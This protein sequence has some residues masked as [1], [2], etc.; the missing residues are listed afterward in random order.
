MRILILVLALGWFTLSAE[1]EAG[2]SSVLRQQ[3]LEAERALRS[4]KRSKY[5]RLLGELEEYP[6]YPYLIYQDLRARLASAPASEVRSFLD[7]W[8]D[9]PLAPRVRSAWLETL[10]RHERWHDYLEHYVESNSVA[11]RCDYL[12]AL[13]R[14]GRAEE[15]FPQVDDLWLHARS[16]PDECDPVFNAWRAGGYLAEELAWARV[17]LAIDAGEIGLASYLRRFVVSSEQADVDRWI[18]TRK[19]P[20]RV[21]ELERYPAQNPLAQQALVAGFQYLARRDAEKA[22]EIWTRVSPRRTWRDEDRNAIERQIGLS[23]AY[24][25]KPQAM[26]W[27]ARVLHEDDRPVQEWRVL[28]ALRHGEWKR[29]LRWLAGMNEEDQHSSRW[30]YWTARCHESLGE[31]SEATLIFERLSRERS[32]YGFLAADRIDRPYEFNHQSL[33]FSDEEPKSI[34]D[35]SGIVRA[36]ELLALK[37]WPDARREWF[38]V[39]KE[40]SDLEAAKAAQLAHDWGWHARA[41]ITLAGT[42]HLDD[43]GLRFPTPHQVDVT[44]RASDYALDRAWVFAVARQES[45]FMPDAR[46]PK[47][48]L[49]LMQIMP[50]TGKDI[51]S[52]LK[53]PGFKT[54]DLLDSAT[55]LR[56]GSWYLRDLLNRMRDHRVLAIA[57]Y[58]AG[59]HRTRRWLPADGA[60]DA[61]IWIET[62]PFRETRRY[63]RRVLAYTVIYEMMLDDPSTRISVRLAPVPSKL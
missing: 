17:R 34:A 27:F 38:H 45:A 16:Q 1:A 36:K 47:G 54:R 23:L 3:F 32:Y 25:H 6:L 50:A 26:D 49:G 62:V 24:R 4:G 39:T 35:L 52:K 28:S 10:A 30:R 21:A 22:A 61:D 43:L 53:K 18:A 48:A 11:R 8:D 5:E 19:D 57:S 12:T 58:N 15:V 51:A 14:T 29:A 2:E 59:P 60:L 40:L 63:L 20:V 13:I 31:T 7:E 9:V 55:N 37:R 56:F 44:G 41:I 46:S 42:E 33:S